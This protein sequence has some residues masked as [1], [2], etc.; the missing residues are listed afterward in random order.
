MS[1]FV[2]QVSFGLV[3]RNVEVEPVLNKLAASTAEVHAVIFKDCGADDVCNPEL[4]LD[5]DL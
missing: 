2:V 3:E 5:A 4:K 1:P